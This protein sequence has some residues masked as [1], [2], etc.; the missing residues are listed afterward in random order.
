VQTDDGDIEGGHVRKT[1]FLPAGPVLY[2]IHITLGSSP[3][4]S[5]GITWSLGIAGC[6]RPF[7]ALPNRWLWGRGD[8]EGQGSFLVAALA[9]ASITPL[10]FGLAFA[11][12]L[13]AQAAASQAAP[14]AAAPRSA[15]ETTG[16]AAANC[17]GR[18]DTLLDILASQCVARRSRSLTYNR[19]FPI[20]V[21]VRIAEARYPE[22]CPVS[23]G[24]PIG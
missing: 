18:P 21:L 20:A 12:E 1:V 23:E 7:G 16:Q 6:A 24:W 22:R 19:S 4:N 9:S 2:L 15:Q 13:P 10:C 11:Q 14:E 8:E 3:Q 17:P 5:G